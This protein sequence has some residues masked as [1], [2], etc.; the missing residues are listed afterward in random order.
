MLQS[1][2]T[3]PQGTWPLVLKNHLS[4]RIPTIPPPAAPGSSFSHHKPQ[5][6][7]SCRYKQSPEAHGNDRSKYSAIL[8]ASSG[9]QHQIATSKP[10]NRGVGEGPTNRRN[11]STLAQFP[12]ENKPRRA[13]GK[14]TQAQVKCWIWGGSQ[15]TCESFLWYFCETW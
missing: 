9:V 7:G 13:H 14:I 3:L 10:Q 4:F 12:R 5:N 2:C 15:Q 8:Q 1:V 11:C 6:P